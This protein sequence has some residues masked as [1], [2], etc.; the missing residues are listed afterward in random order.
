MSVAVHLA[1]RNFRIRQAGPKDPVDIVLGGRGFGTCKPGSTRGMRRLQ[2]VAKGHFETVGRASVAAG[3]G[4]WTTQDRCDGTLTSV[5]T[6]TVGVRDPRRHRT[7]AVHA[8]HRALVKR[9]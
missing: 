4:S 6:G 7:V 5:Q 9:G 8:R 2:A 1:R 3:S